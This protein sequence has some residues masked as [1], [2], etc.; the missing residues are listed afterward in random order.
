M[1]ILFFVA[2]VSLTPICSFAYCGGAHGE[3][4]SLAISIDECEGVIVYS[5]LRKGKS[6]SQEDFHTYKLKEECEFTETGF[7]CRIDGHTPLAGTT[8]KNYTGSNLKN[9][10]PRCNPVFY[11]CDKG[12]KKA[13]VP[14]TLSGVFEIS[15]EGD[16]ND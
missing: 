4:E 8:W 1:R 16:C 6:Q 15:E 13:G 12:C 3:S 7:T 5:Y 10:K 2:A 14:K 9:G 11:V